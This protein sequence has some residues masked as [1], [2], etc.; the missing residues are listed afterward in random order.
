MVVPAAPISNP[1]GCDDHSSRIVGSSPAFARVIDHLPAIAKRDH[2]VL[3]TGET[4]T[5]K[6]L[7]ARL[8]HQLSRR[9][10]APFVAVNCGLL[11]YHLLEDTLFGHERGAF[12]DARFSRAGLIAEAQ[13][14]T[15]LLDEISTLSPGGQVA[16]LRLL[17]ERAYRPMGATSERT[18]DVRFIAAT[19]VSL[20]T[21]V[22][23]EAFRS[24]LYYRL[25]AFRVELPP[26]RERQ[27]DIL[28]LT[29]YFLAKHAPLDCAALRLTEEAELA[30]LS[31]DWPGNVRELEHVIV[32]AVAALRGD[33][34]QVEHLGL[35]SGKFE[36]PAIPRECESFK[37]WRQLSERN[38]LVRL[39]KQ[40][41]GN[42]SQA[43]KSASLDRH[44]L[45]RLL[46]RHRLDPDRFGERSGSS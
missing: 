25:D 6:E 35:P 27:E 32:R 46:T 26:L 34:V 40:H 21:L 11:Q 17:Q 18:M 4:G 20:L 44:A 19:N 37:E 45:R 43:A 41:R 29:R 2:P 14:G 15:L 8:I 1:E 22:K 31:H 36:S 10:A 23:R 42:L 7:I 13:D 12:T 24:D 9:S 38:Y 16:I 39:L 28:Q 5:G 30:L 33:E 3:I